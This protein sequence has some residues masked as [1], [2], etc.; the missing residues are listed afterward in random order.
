MRCRRQL[1]ALQS[2]RGTFEDYLP[3]T[4]ASNGKGG[5]ADIGKTMNT[6][7]RIALNNRLGKTVGGGS[8]WGTMPCGLKPEFA[9]VRRSLQ[10][11]EQTPTTSA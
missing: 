2:H 3:A 10:N 8:Q 6:S 5:Q 7:F 9:Y 11:P 1:R 4:K